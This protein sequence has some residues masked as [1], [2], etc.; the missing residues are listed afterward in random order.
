MHGLLHTPLGLHETH[1]MTIYTEA[2][3]N[4]KM[5]SNWLLNRCPG[6]FGIALCSILKMLHNAVPTPPG[7]RC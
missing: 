6:E 3:I 1:S 7:H 5:V 4:H 2:K